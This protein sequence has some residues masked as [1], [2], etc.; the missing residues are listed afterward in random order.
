MV[1]RRVNV[2]YFGVEIQPFKDLTEN[3]LMQWWSAYN[4]V[5]HAR[6][7]NYKNGNL[8]NVLFALAGLYVLEKELY[9]LITGN[10]KMN[11]ESEFMH[12][13]GWAES[14]HILF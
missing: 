10:E 11:S 5:K 6:I 7:R 9:K 12:M 4:G 13:V 8:E 1:N 3:T 2:D 14:V